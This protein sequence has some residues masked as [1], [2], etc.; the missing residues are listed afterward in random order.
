[1]KKTILFFCIILIGVC[2]AQ[3]NVQYVINTSLERK[4]ISPYIYGTNGQSNDFDLNISSRRLGG[5][6]LTGYNWENNA[7]NAGSDYF[8]VSDNWLISSLNIP[9]RYSDTPGVVL[10]AFH[11]TSLKMRAVTFLT[12]PMAGYVAADKNGT[13]NI[14]QTAPSNRWCEVINDKNAPFLLKPNVLDNKVYIDECL[15][16]LINKYGKANSDSGIKGYALDNEPDLWTST[17]PRI[18][19]ERPTISQFINR[20]VSLATTIKRMDPYADVIGLVSFGWGGF[21]T[22]NNAPD[23]NQYRNKRYAWFIDA[24]LAEMKKKS[25]SLKIRLVDVLALHWYPEALGYSH[26]S[27]NYE[28]VYNSANPADSGVAKAR[29]QSVRSLYDPRYLEN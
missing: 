2:L 8:H 26:T 16:F 5:N 25:D 28:R 23:W 19:P 7:S 14:L 1:M 10:T 29:M 20:S 4:P 9:S 27:G 6:R 11:D 3:L 21:Q 15:N 12:L 22:F 13:V 24:Y 18:V 17:H